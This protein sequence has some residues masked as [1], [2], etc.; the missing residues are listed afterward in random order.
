[1]IDN[2]QEMFTEPLWKNARTSPKFIEYLKEFKLY[3]F[4]KD[5]PEIKKLEKGK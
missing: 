5:D 4:W 3:D 2:N 1:M